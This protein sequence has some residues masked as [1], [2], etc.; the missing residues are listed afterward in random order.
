V[1]ATPVVLGAPAVAVRRRYKAARQ[2]ARRPAAMIALAVVTGF[3]V[4]ALAAP[5]LAPYDPI[6]IKFP[7]PWPLSAEF[8]TH[9]GYKPSQDTPELVEAET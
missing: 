4:V 3:V 5:H 9:M 1:S 2:L 8:P 7:K 6:T